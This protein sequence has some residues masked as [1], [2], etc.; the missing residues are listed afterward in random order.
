MAK[1]GECRLIV[2]EWLVFP[3][4]YTHRTKGAGSNPTEVKLPLEEFS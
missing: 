3:K 1:R 4:W 2:V